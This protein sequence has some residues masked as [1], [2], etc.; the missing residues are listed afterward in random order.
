MDPQR[1]GPPALGL[2]LTDSHFSGCPHHHTIICIEFSPSKHH[3][4]SWDCLGMSTVL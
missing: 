3:R 4:H 1:K 2:G